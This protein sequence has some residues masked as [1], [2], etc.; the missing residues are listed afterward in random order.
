M[1]SPGLPGERE[2]QISEESK[3]DEAKGM[4]Y[5]IDS[6]WWNWILSLSSPCRIWQRIL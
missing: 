3:T 4:A 5:S 2:E 6:L 1:A